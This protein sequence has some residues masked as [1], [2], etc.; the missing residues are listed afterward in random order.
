MLR[1][2]K[3]IASLGLAAAGAVATGIAVLLQKLPKESAQE[4]SPAAGTAR[5]ITGAYSFIS[6]FQDAVTVEMLLDY[7][8][9]KLSFAIVEDEFLSY[10]SDS[11]VAIMYGEDFNLQFEYAGYY[12]GEDF[13]A[14]SRALLE[15]H[16][17]GG[18]IICGALQGVWVL[19]G[20]NVTIHFPIPD[21]KHSYLLVTVQK[22]PDYDDEVTT[23]PAYTPLRELLSTIRFRKV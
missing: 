21:D 7:D 15:K 23:L 20:D 10:T 17:T 18:G 6:G 4:T 12:D 2:W 13:A 1:K 8:P 9:E 19:D 11:H 16:P 22:T 14:H 5:L 3:L